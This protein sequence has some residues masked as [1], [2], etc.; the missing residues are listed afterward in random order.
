MI[1]SIFFSV[2]NK[3][4]LKNKNF[5]IKIFFNLWF[6]LLNSNNLEFSLADTFRLAKDNK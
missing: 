5:I 2:F 3:K 1:N 6:F 4:K